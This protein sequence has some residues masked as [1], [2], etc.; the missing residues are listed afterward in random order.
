MKRKGIWILLVVVLSLIIVFGS[1]G[2]A[3]AYKGKPQATVYIEQYTS[4]ELRLRAPITY[5]NQRAYGSF[6]KWYLVVGDTLTPIQ[7]FNQA[8][9]ERLKWLVKEGKLHL[10]IKE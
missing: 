8:K 7:I 5:D 6:A 10:S 9:S 1:V 4:G 3:E 2:V